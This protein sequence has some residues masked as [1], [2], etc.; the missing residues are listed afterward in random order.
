MKVMNPRVILAGCAKRRYRGTGQKGARGE[1]SGLRP[2]WPSS[3]AQ[4]LEEGPRVQFL[5]ADG[6]QPYGE[7]ASS[8][9]EALAKEVLTAWREVRS[10]RKKEELVA[11]AD[12]A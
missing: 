6:L 7:L 4:V 2:S 12:A 9:Q 8:W 3:L 5:Q 1:G 11:L 10:G